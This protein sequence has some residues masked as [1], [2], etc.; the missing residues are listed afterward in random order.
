LGVITNRAINAPTCA[1]NKITVIISYI[2]RKHLFEQQ[3]PIR[4]MKLKNTMNP[5]MQ[6]KAMATASMDVKLSTDSKLAISFSLLILDH[7]RTDVVTTRAMPMSRNK[8][9]IKPSRNRNNDPQ[10]PMLLS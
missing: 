2:M 10:Q 1:I 3:T 9:L 7:L 8:M 5:P 6:S 4:P